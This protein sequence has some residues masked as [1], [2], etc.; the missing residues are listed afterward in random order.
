MEVPRRLLRGRGDRRQQAPFLVDPVTDIEKEEKSHKKYG[1]RQ[2]FEYTVLF[3]YLVY[4][5]V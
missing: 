5:E 1:H 4:S 2:A 3:M